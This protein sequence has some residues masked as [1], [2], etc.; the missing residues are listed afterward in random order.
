[1]KL[2]CWVGIHDWTK[3]Y[4]PGFGLYRR[5]MMC[6][7]YQEGS[8]F[9]IFWYDLSKTHVEIINRMAFNAAEMLKYMYGL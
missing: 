4:I 9:G 6:N 3:F 7:K 5:C 2:F 8:T 1:M